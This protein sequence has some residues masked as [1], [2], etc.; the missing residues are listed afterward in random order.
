MII[1]YDPRLAKPGPSRMQALLD[2]LPIIAFA[3]TYWITGSFDTAIIVIMIAMA[4]Q[5]ALTWL[6][7]R[8]VGRMLQVSAA[9]VWVL[10]AIT[11]WLDNELIFK[12]KPT[13]LYWL[14]AAAFFGSRY[15]GEKPLVQ[16]MLLSVSDE[17][18]CLDRTR[19]SQLNAMWAGFFIFAGVANI[20]VAYLF[21][22]AVWVNFKL[23]G[24]LGLTMGFMVLQAFWISH[25]HVEETVESDRG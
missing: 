4:V 23:F 15:I 18:I 20:I 19:W 8:T 12:W 24:L 11:L 7:R 16:R 13:I 5:V 2:F 17:K 22:E 14:F 1:Q 3:A 10:G 21:S 9:L 25:H 6:L